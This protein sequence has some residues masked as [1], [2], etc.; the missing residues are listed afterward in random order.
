MHYY[1]RNIGDY[2]KKAGRLTMLQHGAYCLLLDACYDR[3]QFPTKIEAVDW[4]WASSK[5]EIDAVEFVLSKFFTEQEG[6]RFEQSRVKD[7]IEE[8]VAICSTN[9]INGKKGGRPKNSENKPKKTQSVN[10][11]TQSVN[12]ETEPK[13]DRNPNKDKDNYN[14]KNKDLKEYLPAADP[15]IKKPDPYENDIKQIFEHW[16]TV[17]AKN[18]PGEKINANRKKLITARLKNDSSISELMLAIDGCAAS[19]WNMINGVNGINHIFKDRS[20]VRK[21]LSKPSGQ[22]FTKKTETKQE[23]QARLFK[24][25]GLGDDIEGE[26]QNV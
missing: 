4:L 8:W 25:L 23:H 16:R 21:Y 3:E 2:H 24:E 6:G 20:N 1:K 22:S 11:E 5:E 13:P 12:L 15:K 17:I 10:L 7:G 9:Q 19:E 26:F 14:Y 18:D